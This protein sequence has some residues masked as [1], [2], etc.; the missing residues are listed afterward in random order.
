MSV[1]PVEIEEAF[2]IPQIRKLSLC[3]F[4]GNCNAACHSTLSDFAMR[5]SGFPAPAVG[6]T[7]GAL[8]RKRLKQK[9]RV[10]YCEGLG[11]LG[12]LG[13][14][15]LTMSV[16]GGRRG[17]GLLRETREQLHVPNMGN[18][19][20]CV[21]E[22]RQ[23]NQPLQRRLPCRSHSLPSSLERS[24]CGRPSLHVTRKPKTP[25]SQK[26]LEAPEFLKPPRVRQTR[27]PS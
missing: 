5:D 16:A 1:L 10:Q 8:S 3:P 21:S 19:S 22:L 2:L 23:Q 27:D 26:P 15:R 12:L 11:R 9:I 18:G 25:T 20:T 17:E 7:E 14:A 24:G 6:M 4:F 13:W